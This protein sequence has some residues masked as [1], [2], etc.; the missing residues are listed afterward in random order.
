MLSTA[1]VDILQLSCTL[2]AA[3]SAT[4]L[5]RDSTRGLMLTRQTL[6]TT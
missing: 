4:C 1:D 3:A 2:T 5:I 6:L